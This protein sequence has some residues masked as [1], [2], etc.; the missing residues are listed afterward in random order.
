MCRTCGVEH[1]ARPDVCA[2]CADDR[3]WVPATG[4]AWATLESLAAEGYEASIGELEPDLHAITSTPG[5]GIGQQSKLVVTPDGNV[6]WD[7]IGFLDDAVVEAV[8]ALGPVVAIVASHPHMYGVQVEWSRRLGNV[9]VLVAESDVHWLG[10]PDPV[11][12]TWTGERELLPGVTLSQPG[13][14]LP[15]GAV[16]HWAAGADG[17]GVLLAGDTIF[18][19]PDRRSVAFMRSFPNHI[20]L[21]A[22]VVERVT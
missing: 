17:R 2:I 3:Q 19:T 9:P 6:L 21:S 16:L 13:G 11:V 8:R 15:G 5:A 18:A 1:A 10:R 22:G 14:H 20:P 4:Q 12:R 7:P